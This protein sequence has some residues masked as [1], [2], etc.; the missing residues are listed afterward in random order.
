[1]SAAMIDLTALIEQANELEPL[2]PTSV[3]LAELISDPNYYLD[4]VVD[5]ITYDQALTL[6]LLRTA[7]SAASGTTERIGSVK[8]AINRMGVAQVLALTIA[9]KVRPLLQASIPAYDLDEGSLWQHSVTAAI[10]LETLQSRC[11]FGAPPEAFTAALLHDVGKLVMA[12]FLDPEIVGFLRCAKEQDCL[13]E[14]EAE[15]LLLSV[16]HAE[17]GG[18]IAQHWNLPSRI[19]L[20]VTYHHNPDQGQDLIC[21]LT[22]MANQLAHQ[23]AARLRGQKTERIISPSVAHRLALSA[24]VILEL[25]PLATERYIQVS[26]RFNAA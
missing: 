15:T 11:K 25:C 9:S 2:S 1:M 14:V 24:E 22:Y 6:K 18:V 4:D 13:D 16:H 7:N 20:G 5:L 26:N 23:V 19:V 21:D 8:E 12:R 17:L 3:R 10:C